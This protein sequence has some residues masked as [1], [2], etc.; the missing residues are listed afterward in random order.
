M[1][2][3]NNSFIDYLLHKNS[4]HFQVRKLQK[5]LRDE[6]GSVVMMSVWMLSF[7][8][9]L[10][11][12]DYSPMLWKYNN[13]NMNNKPA[14]NVL[15]WSSPDLHCEV[16]AGQQLDT[17]CQGELAVSSVLQVPGAGYICPEIK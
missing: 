3:S 12:A 8:E 13:G 10:E 7:D 17:S 4:T 9:W 16:I 5:K 14:G 6:D 15:F 11:W 2:T 1:A